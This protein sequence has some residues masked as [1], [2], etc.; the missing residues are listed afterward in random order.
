MSDKECVHILIC[1]FEQVH[2]EQYLNSLKNSTKVAEIIEVKFSFSSCKYSL[3]ILVICIFRFS[4]RQLFYL[5]V[6]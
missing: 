2:T 3:E 6:S 1:N 4:A 5:C